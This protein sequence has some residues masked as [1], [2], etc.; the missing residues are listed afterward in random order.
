MTALVQ[1][2]LTVRRGARGAFGYFAAFGLGLLVV[3]GL[4]RQQKALGVEHAIVFAAWAVVLAARVH[5]RVRD[6]R[7]DE[8][9][10][11]AQSWLD[12]EVALLLLPAAHALLQMAGGLG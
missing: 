8:T 12:F 9:R 1:A 4:F 5:S 11:E 7:R 6:Q 10:N 3:L 2:A